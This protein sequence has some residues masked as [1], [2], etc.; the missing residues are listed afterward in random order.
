MLFFTP[1]TKFPG[2]KDYAWLIGTRGQT[3]KGGGG[4]RGGNHTALLSQ[5]SCLFQLANI[6]T[7]SPGLYNLL[8]Y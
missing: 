5:F 4:G 3:E 6:K 2:S 1:L 7:F 8:K